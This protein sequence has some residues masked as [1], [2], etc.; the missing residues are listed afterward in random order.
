MSTESKWAHTW[1][2]LD[3]Y[4]LIYMDLTCNQVGILWNL[5][6]ADSIEET[7]ILIMI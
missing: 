3:E 7:F 6:C 1:A 2:E 4:Q 5:E